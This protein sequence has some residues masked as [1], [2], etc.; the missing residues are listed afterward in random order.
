MSRAAKIEDVASRAGVS[1]ATV[2]RALRGLP[3]VSAATREKVLRAAEELDYRPNPHAARLAA[4]RSGTVGVAVPVLNSWFYANVLAGVEAVLAEEARHARDRGRRPG[5]HER[6]IAGLPALSKRVDGLVLC[7]LF[8]PD[9]LWEDLA[10]GRFP[11]PP[12]AS[13]PACSTR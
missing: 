12:W 9:Q 1:V 5:C 3:H 2:S 4:G 7:D 10:G 13:T 6:F 8:M 11:S